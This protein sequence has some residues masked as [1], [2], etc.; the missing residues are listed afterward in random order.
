[1]TI[2][3]EICSG[4]SKNKDPIVPVVCAPLTRET[5]SN[6]NNPVALVVLSFAF[7]LI[8]LHNSLIPL[9]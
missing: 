5:P 8:D 4:L 3:F 7:R 1:M 6:A 9:L 2:A